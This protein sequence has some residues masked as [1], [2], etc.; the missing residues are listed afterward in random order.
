[1]V[2]LGMTSSF[3]LMGNWDARCWIHQATFSRWLRPSASTTLDCTGAA[4]SLAWSEPNGAPTTVRTA[5]LPFGL[6]GELD[7]RLRDIVRIRGIL[8]LERQCQGRDHG[9]GDVTDLA[10]GLGD[11]DACGRLDV[12]EKAGRVSA[13]LHLHDL[14]AELASPSV[15]V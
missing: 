3:R 11:F 13:R 6:A 9:A 12:G 10:I 8:A 14:D 5:R 7:D 4:S 2:G 15:T 1:M